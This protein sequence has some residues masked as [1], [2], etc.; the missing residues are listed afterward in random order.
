MPNN[1]NY[2]LTR[3]GKMITVSDDELY[4]WK[5][6]KREKV[7]GKWV[8]TYP[9]DK[10]G[11]K[12]FIDTKITGKAYKQHR[13]E[14]VAEKTKI[15][16]EKFST[17]QSRIHAEQTLYDQIKSDETARAKKAVED[18]KND[19]DKIKEEMSK[20]QPGTS[21][22]YDAKQRYTNAVLDKQN[23]NSTKSTTS[24]GTKTEEEISSKAA[25]L[26]NSKVDELKRKEASLDKQS[27]QYEQEIIDARN[28]YYNNSLMG[29]SQKTVNRGKKAVSKML[30]KL[31]DKID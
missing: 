17:T 6:I 9:N 5:Y 13:D 10:L 14:A 27:K 22:Y 7:N 26:A 21:E 18:A 8:Y 2:L 3:E 23:K 30:R 16:S 11:I 28:N 24:N 20:L 29:I 19:P 1:N 31:A 4:H 15:N 25:K 12:N